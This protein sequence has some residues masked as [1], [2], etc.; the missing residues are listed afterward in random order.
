M[1]PP[2]LLYFTRYSSS[3]ARDYLPAHSH[4]SSSFF[5]IYTIDGPLYIIIEYASHGNL[6]DYLGMCRE[7]LLQ[8]NIVIRI[9]SEKGMYK[10]FYI[11]CWYR[12]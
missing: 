6:K 12:Y 10:L 7:V 1:Q 11:M 8:R 2:G 5:F 3:L 9:S 4:S